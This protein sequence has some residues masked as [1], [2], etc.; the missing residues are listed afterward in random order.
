MI[1]IKNNILVN[2]I[3]IFPLSTPECLC[4]MQ[5]FC[6]LSVCSGPFEN[7][8]ERPG[9]LVDPHGPWLWFYTLKYRSTHMDL[10]LTADIHLAD[11]H[12]E[13]LAALEEIVRTANEE[14]V[15]YVLIA[16][17]LFDAG[18]DIESMKPHI[19]DVF[20][21]NSFHAF[22]IP[23]NHDH[24]AFRDEDY[25]GEDI[26]VLSA[27][28]FETREFDRVNLI[29]LPYHDGGFS[30]LLDEIQTARI[31]KKLNIL[32]MHGTLS[33]TAGKSTGDEPRYM[34]FN[35]EQLVASGMEYVFAGHI[36]SSPTQQSFGT[37]DCVF[38]YP[39][40]PVSITRSETGPRGVWVFDTTTES[41]RNLP[42]DTPYYIREELDLIPGEAPQK[43][44]ALRERLADKDLSNA[45]LLIEPTGFI[46][47]PETEFFDSLDSIL[48]NTNAAGYEI[49]R[50]GIQS[51]QSILDS[52]LYH[53]FTR[54]LTQKPDVDT[55][56]V[57]RIALRALS[58]EARE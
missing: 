37:N 44:D 13:R 34:P 25:F 7:Q 52:D 55:R 33:T 23:G 54:K 18:L 47:T 6:R 10:L 15:S 4:T 5:Y 49:D 2:D 1:I 38:V 31:E 28:P 43:L 22:V 51:A 27:E 41:F 20:S 40:S 24:G 57:R 42:L 35:P 53:G 17:D 14:D 32:L 26:E 12:P 46:E 39:G 16:G 48:T 58:R 50:T 36:H 29:A 8:N 19:R 45:T 9:T 56:A 3:S 11:S 30:D 21:G